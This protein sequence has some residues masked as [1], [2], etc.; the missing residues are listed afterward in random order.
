MFLKKWH[1]TLISIQKGQRKYLE[2]N[3]FQHRQYS[4]YLSVKQIYEIEAY[5]IVS[6][7]YHKFPWLY[8]CVQR[9]DLTEVGDSFDLHQVISENR[10]VEE[11]RQSGFNQIGKDL[12]EVKEECGQS[13]GG[14][15][16][17]KRDQEQ[18]QGNDHSERF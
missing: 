5:E 1:L 11:E 2:E 10:N 14:I 6:H 8:N 7:M 12:N 17:Q 15:N 18:E 4:G 16:S 9:M 13:I 3:G